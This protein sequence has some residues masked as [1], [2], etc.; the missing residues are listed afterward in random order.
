L[1]QCYISQ[2]IVAYVAG[3][4]FALI[5]NKVGYRVATFIGSVITTIGFITSYFAT[6]LYHLYFTYGLLQGNI[7]ALLSFSYSFT[8]ILH[9]V[10]PLLTFCPLS[11][12]K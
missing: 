9:Y 1:K 11:Y 5:I 6:E 10:I 7:L 8:E 2:S 3:P 12:Y 4:L